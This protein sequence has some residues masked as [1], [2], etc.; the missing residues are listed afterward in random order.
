MPSPFPGMDP[1][2]EG[3]RWLTFHRDMCT[4]MRRQLVS[5]IPPHYWPETAIYYEFDAPQNLDF[6]VEEMM[7][8]GSAKPTGPVK[9]QLAP[10]PHW[11]ID[12]LE[13]SQNK[14]VTVIEMLSPATKRGKGRR[15]YLRKRNR[16]L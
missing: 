2:L 5:K 16:I 12:I 15:Q 14:V 7:P 1:Y 13:K 8:A 3:N 4:E 6:L 10:F 11:R 9:I